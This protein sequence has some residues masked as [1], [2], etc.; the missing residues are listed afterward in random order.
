MRIF[1]LRWFF[2][3]GFVFLIGVGVWAVITITRMKRE[4][5]VALGILN[6]LAASAGLQ[7]AT[8]RL[9]SGAVSS[10]A[11]ETRDEDDHT[12]R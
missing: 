5:A 4:Q 10:A 2:F 9:Q 12:T 1:L 6:A 11:R 7:R 8:D 3:G